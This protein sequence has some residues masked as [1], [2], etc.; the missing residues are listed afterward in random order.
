MGGYWERLL[1]RGPRGAIVGIAILTGILSISSKATAIDAVFRVTTGT[2]F[3]IG[4]GVV[5][6]TN[7]GLYPDGTAF[8]V[9]LQ[10][11]AAPNLWQVTFGEVAV[12]T[13]EFPF[14]E[15]FRFQLLDEFGLPTDSVTLTLNTDTG[16]MGFPES[17]ELIRIEMRQIRGSQTLAQ[18]IFD[19]PLTTGTVLRPDCSENPATSVTGMHVGSAEGETK[20]ISTACILELPPVTGFN[21]AMV[22][23]LVGSFDLTCADGADNDSDGLIDLADPGCRDVLDDD[24]DDR[25][26][27]GVVDEGEECDDGNIVSGD[28]CSD[29]CT[30]EPLGSSCEDGNLCT[31]GDTCNGAGICTTGSPLVCDDGRACNGL[32]S[33]DPGIGCLAGPPPDVDDGIACTVVGCAPFEDR[34]IHVPVHS[35]CSDSVF[36]NGVEICNLFDGCRPASPLQIDDGVACTTDFCDESSDQIVHVPDHSPC[37]DG[38][39]CNGEERCEPFVGCEGGTP[40]ATADG[41]G[42]T[43]D[44]CDESQDLV[45]HTPDSTLCND[46]LFCNGA[47]LCN[48]TLDCQAGTVPPGAGGSACTVASCDEQQDRVV[49]IPVGSFC[50]DGD[51]CTA[52]SCDAFGGCVHET[53]EG[54]APPLE[55][56]TLFVDSFDATDPS[57]VDGGVHIGPPA[58]AGFTP[59]S[60]DVTH[61]GWYGG[62][63]DGGGGAIG[64]DL[65]LVE[66][67][68]HEPFMVNDAACEDRAA[69]L[70]HLDTTPYNEDSLQLSFD[71][72]TRGKLT[73]D[74]RARVGYASGDTVV[75]ASEGTTI[76]DVPDGEY[77]DFN[78]A[79]APDDFWDQ[80]FT[81][82]PLSSNGVNTSRDPISEQ[83]SLPSGV[84]S[85]WV[86]FW[87]DASESDYFSIDNVRIEGELGV[88]NPCGNGALDAFEQCD[89]GNRVGGDGCDPECRIDLDNDATSD[90]ADNCPADFNPRQ[91][92]L[93]LDG[94]GDACDLDDDG[95]GVTDGFDNCPLIANGTQL[96]SDLDGLG[97]PC[98]PQLDDP[99]LGVGVVTGPGTTRKGRTVQLRGELRNDGRGVANLPPIGLLFFLSEDPVIEPGTDLTLTSCDVASVAPGHTATCDSPTIVLTWGVPEPPP[100]ETELRYWGACA[101]MPGAPGLGDPEACAAGNAVFFVPEPLLAYLQLGALL[102]LALTA[103]RRRS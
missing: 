2:T 91:E 23:K 68:M 53:I 67:R 18:G 4:S 63:L 101:T 90:L 37:N 33:C 66:T 27:D 16:E 10:P 8:P 92:D 34:V 85:L 13:I 82:L 84:E 48:P 3:L 87:A 52:D 81:E 32:E 73:G 76:D 29:V 39:F 26:G 60:V 45:V 89:D 57:P 59:P 75:D 46:G 58:N 15:I 103:Q 47:E 83:L 22:F 7:P 50:N 100:G 31:E 96:D 40:V 54:C 35:L 55:Q 94:A 38:L 69:F 98:D 24:E 71:W 20:L 12:P 19:V 74:E 99:D 1:S 11:G 25:C 9:E 51:D 77:L 62:R 5:L 42:C 64:A 95:D 30:L 43:H 41:V 102:A 93:D 86:T 14:S 49:Q 28:C 61:E 70:I 21:M 6:D 88:F 65:L 17:G 78:G 80:A 72:V 44:F 97:E 79:S 36:C 56:V